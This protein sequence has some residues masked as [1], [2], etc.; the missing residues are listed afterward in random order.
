[1]CL[2]PL[3]EA[4]RRDEALLQAVQIG[5]GN[6]AVRLRP[7]CRAAARHL[8]DHVDRIA[9]AQEILRPALAPIRGAG[10]IGAGLAAAMD[11]HHG[12][13]V[14]EPLRHLVFHIH[15][16]DGRRPLTVAVDGAADKEIALL[17]DDQRSGLGAHAG[18]RQ[19]RRAGPDQGGRRRP[20][21][22]G[23][24]P[25]GALTHVR[26]SLAA[27]HFGDVRLSLGATLFGVG[28]AGNMAGSPGPSADF[29]IPVRPLT[30]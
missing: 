27:L 24:E 23:E 12:I 6:R 8:V 17:G 25:L 22:R 3:I 2:R 16:A 29:L 11:H 18:E 15:V 21:N 19:Q 9:P 1:M 30:P 7:L 14:R 20:Q 10:E 28:P 4:L 26:S 13:G 5:G